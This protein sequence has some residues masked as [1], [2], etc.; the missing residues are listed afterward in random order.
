VLGVSAASGTVFPSERWSGFIRA[1]TTETRVYVYPE[2]G[3]VVTT[4]VTERILFLLNGGTNPQAAS[5]GIDSEATFTNIP[6]CIPGFLIYRITENWS[7]SSGLTSNLEGSA[8]LPDLL[9]GVAGTYRLAPG[10][11]VADRSGSTTYCDGSEY[12]YPPGPQSIGVYASFFYPLFPSQS[13]ETGWRTLAGSWADTQSPPSPGTAT[14]TTNWE[15]SLTKLDDRDHDGVPDD[16]DKCPDVFDPCPAT[17]IV[18][19]QTNPNGAPGSFSFTGDAAG[20]VAD[21]GQIIVANLPP[22]TYTSTEADPSPSQFALSSIACD[23]G[24]SAT[25]SAGDL[26][27][28]TATFELDPGETVKCIFTNTTAFHADTIGFWKNHLANSNSKGPFYSTDCTTISK[29]GGSCSQKG[30]WAIQYLPV[31]L[32][33][34]VVDSITKAAQVFKAANCSSGKDQD[35]VGCLAGQLLAT[36]LNLANGSLQCAAIL[37]AVAD[38]DAFLKGQTVIGVPGINYT[39]PTGKYT[40]T[41]AARNLLLS[42]KTKLDT[43]NNSIACP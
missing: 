24:G 35:A 21:N 2:N 38:A 4:E 27:T 25:P 26:A 6:E 14:L 36:K 31:L 17:I 13:A 28:R 10:T 39:G 30:P 15:W 1:E 16:D 5:G 11:I 41:A 19:K 37:Q 23:D 3:V 40:L 42:L 32:G 8:F 20:T 18:E 33:T 43:Y 29:S 22:G 7:A 34:Y 9:P 12:P